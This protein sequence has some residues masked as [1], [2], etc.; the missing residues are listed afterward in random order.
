[1]K[2]QPINDPGGKMASQLHATAI[3]KQDLPGPVIKSQTGA[4]F[5]AV[6][7]FGTHRRFQKDED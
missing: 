7:D 1:M 2:G 6:Q 4:A 5:A 3:L